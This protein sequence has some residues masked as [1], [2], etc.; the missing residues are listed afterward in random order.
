MHRSKHLK[1][2]VYLVLLNS[3]A[4][5]KV[6]FKQLVESLFSLEEFDSELLFRERETEIEKEQ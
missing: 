1:Y 3:H 4:V 5:F 6:R 2:I